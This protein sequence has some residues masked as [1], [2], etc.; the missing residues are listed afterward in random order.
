MELFDVERDTWVRSWGP[1]AVS[2]VQQAPRLLGC[3]DD[4]TGFGALTD[5]CELVRRAHHE[6][7]N[8]RI[9]ATD[10][11]AEALAPA[12]IEQKVTGPEAFGGLR[13]LWRRYGEAAPGPAS[14]EGHRAHGMLVPP[15]PQTWAQIPSFEF[16]RAGVDARRAAVLVRAMTRLPSLDRALRAAPDNAERAR[17]L[18]T[19]PGIGPWTAAKVMQWAYGDADAWSTGDYHAPGLISLALCG[20]RLDNDGAEELLRPYAGHRFRVELLVVGMVAKGSRRGPRM[21][22]PGHVPGVAP[23]AALARG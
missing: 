7:P 1:G 10:N 18:Q 8:L 16:T 12:A 20:R 4:P 11:L 22:L 6:H 13:R 5:R 2:A 19:L 21:S 3:D 17:L 14:S 9:G 23:R 15:A